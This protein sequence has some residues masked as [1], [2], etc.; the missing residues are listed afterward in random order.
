[1]ANPVTSS[2]VNVYDGVPAGSVLLASAVIMETS[3]GSFT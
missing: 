3:A 2:A 1:M